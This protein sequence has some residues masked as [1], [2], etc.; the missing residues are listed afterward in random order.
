[1]VWRYK[2]F[3][4]NLAFDAAYCVRCHGEISGAHYM[5]V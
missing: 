2:S 3:F 4:V 5:N 1:M